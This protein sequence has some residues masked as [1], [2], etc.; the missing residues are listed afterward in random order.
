LLLDD[1]TPTRLDEL[2]PGL[3]S[4]EGACDA[5]KT[6]MGGIWLSPHLADPIVLRKPLPP[7]IQAKL[8]KKKKTEIYC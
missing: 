2:V 7:V 8:V 5:A 6:G 3:A 4:Y 1:P